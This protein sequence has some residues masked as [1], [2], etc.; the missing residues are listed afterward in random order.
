MFF[1][2][3]II[4]FIYITINKINVLSNK[5]NIQPFTGWINLLFFENI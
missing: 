3:N 1:L 2:K 4:K 5:K